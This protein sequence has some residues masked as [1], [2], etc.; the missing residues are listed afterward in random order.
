MISC[1]RNELHIMVWA[2][3]RSI[4]LALFSELWILERPKVP[5]QIHH[6]L[7][8]LNFCQFM[9]DVVNW[10][11][12]FCKQIIFKAFSITPLYLNLFSNPSFISKA[13]THICLSTIHFNLILPYTCINWQIVLKILELLK[14]STGMCLLSVKTATCQIESCQWLFSMCCSISWKQPPSSLHSD[15]NLQLL[16]TL[17]NVLILCIGLNW[18]SY[19][20]YNL[21]LS[22]FLKIVTQ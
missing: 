5:Q 9:Y 17:P 6:S 11:V 14:P 10:A 8:T 19:S 2:E 18:Y 12:K 22:K 7:E 4:Q 15:H 20:A 21:R 3:Q 13:P 1:N 16:F